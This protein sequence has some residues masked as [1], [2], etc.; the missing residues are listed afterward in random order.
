LSRRILVR[1]GR[2]LTMVPGAA[3][4]RADVLLDG[5][6]I[7]DVAARIDAADCDV[8][9]ASGMIVLPGFVDTHR[10]V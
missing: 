7:A 6:R 3:E 8:V 1:G 5:D 10:H 2:V 4:T 9:D